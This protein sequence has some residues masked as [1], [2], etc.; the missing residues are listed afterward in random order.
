MKLLLRILSLLIILAL[1]S[2]LLFSC[3]ESETGSSS[4]PDSN[5]SS[6]HY[7]TF[8]MKNWT[9]TKEG[10]YNPCTCHPE[11]IN[12]KSHI[13][14]L[15]RNGI[16]DVCKYVLMEPDTYTVTIVD[17]EGKPVT[18][19]VFLFRSNNDVKATTDENGQASV[20][21]T[22]VSGVNVV[23][24]SLPEGYAMPEKP[25]FPFSGFELT[26]TV[27]K[28]AIQPNSELHSK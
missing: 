7:H 21:F 23:I 17:T 20:E 1:A 10:H 19:A 4:T 27:E 5:E 22:D 24:E 12:L 16:C 3:G 14:H 11:I 8:D 25:I 9:V 18:G 26:I 13:D 2:P 6:V 28:E 15:D